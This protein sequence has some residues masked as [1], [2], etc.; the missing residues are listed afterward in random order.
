[1]CISSTSCKNIASFIDVQTAELQTLC[2]KFL[3]SAKLYKLFGA[4]SM[5][6]GIFCLQKVLNFFRN[7]GTLDSICHTVKW[8]IL[9]VKS[10]ISQAE[11]FA[12]ITS[13]WYF[14]MS[15]GYVETAHIWYITL[16]AVTVV[17]CWHY[18]ARERRASRCDITKHS[19]HSTDCCVTDGL[20]SRHCQSQHW[21][22]SPVWTHCIIYYFNEL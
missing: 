15:H 18:R 7:M 1:M 20:W 22:A 5:F 6:L 12:F 9:C 4:E 11:L 19:Y 8:Y 10:A 2:A 3:K 21:S 13:M 17:K 16:T 14:Y